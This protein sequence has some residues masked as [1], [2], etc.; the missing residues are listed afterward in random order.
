MNNGLSDE[1]KAA[2]PDITPV[3]RPEV[4]NQVIKDPNWLSGF[5]EGDG[6]FSI[7]VVKSSRSKYGALVQLFFNITQHSRDEQLLKSLVNYLGC[8]GYYL[9]SGRDLGKFI[10][11]RFSDIESKI[12]P[13]FEKYPPPLPRRPPPPVGGGGGRGARSKIAGLCRFQAGC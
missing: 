11:T 3:P 2:F 12:M 9:V 5:V 6:C 8:G 1:L 10:V 7:C 4:T 13:F